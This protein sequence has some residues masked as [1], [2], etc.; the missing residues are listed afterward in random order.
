MLK[1]TTCNKYSYKE[2]KWSNTSRQKKNNAFMY[3]SNVKPLGG[4][5]LLREG[6]EVPGEEG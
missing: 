3:D 6:S 1:P 5:D 2:I 4:S